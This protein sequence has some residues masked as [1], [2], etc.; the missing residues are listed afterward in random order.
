MTLIAE[1]K[2]MAGLERLPSLPAVMNHILAVTSSPDA[3]VDDVARVVSED[4]AIAAKI[5]RVANSPYY[6]VRRE[7]TEVS[8]AV[9][10]LGMVA[11]R[12]LAIGLCARDALQADD[13]DTEQHERLWR[14]AIAVASAS[15]LIA[16]RVGYR[17]PEEAFVAGLL[18]DVG[19]LA[20]LIL[21]PEPLNRILDGQAHAVD[22]LS[23]ERRH[24]GTDHG[25]AGHRLLTRW[26]LPEVICDITRHHHGA[27]SESELEA[28]PLPGIVM[29][30]NTLVNMEGIGFDT[31]LTD[32]P[33][34]ERVVR[35]F[36][37]DA[38]TMRSLLEN[39]VRRA[40]E[41]SSMF[42]GVRWRHPLRGEEDN[43]QR[44][45]VWITREPSH[46]YRMA[47]ALLEHR[48]YTV[49]QAT[50]EKASSLPPG[51]APVV[52]DLCDGELQAAC[53]GLLDRGHATLVTLVD[54]EPGAPLR[55]RD[56]AA[57]ACRIPRCFTAFDL[58]WMEEQLSR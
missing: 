25:E 17:P 41:A 46:H 7:I 54:P 21:D 51:S 5:L 34:I 50:P 42:E 3:S 35:H 37:L 23:E 13:R 20:M 44:R 15:D 39:T 55:A 10:R 8:R 52:L 57:G 45:I 18:H 31:P 6:R 19:R 12:N 36:K 24:L 14:H 33:C 22:M 40:E 9:L 29:L 56:P 53:A 16:R 32:A 28:S 48:G 27:I 26:G 11:V 58:R 47:R 43:G 1:S 4:P 49:Q 2:V 30:A 38:A